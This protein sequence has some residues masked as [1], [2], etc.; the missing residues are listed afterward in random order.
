MLVRFTFWYI[1]LTF[2]GQAVT[3]DTFNKLEQLQNSLKE[4]K[5][6]FQVTFSLALPSSFLLKAP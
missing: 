4:R 5:L 2:P 1:T 3:L 6:L